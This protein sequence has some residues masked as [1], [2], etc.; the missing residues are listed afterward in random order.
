MDTSVVTET[1]VSKPVKGLKLSKRLLAGFFSFCLTASMF[2][3][4]AF[5]ADDSGSGVDYSGIGDA[6]KSGLST[7]VTNCVTVAST[8]IPIG[9]GLWGLSLMIS[10]VKK[11]IVKLTG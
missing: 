6:L 3:V 5:A 10:F 2:V 4:Q 9:V 1:A 11:F 7:C 8:L